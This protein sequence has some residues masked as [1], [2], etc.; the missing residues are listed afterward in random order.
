MFRGILAVIVL[1]SAVILMEWIYAIDRQY[2]RVVSEAPVTCRISGISS[3]LYSDKLYLEKIYAQC[4]NS[5][6]RLRVEQ[7]LPEEQVSMYLGM[8]LE[9]IEER[10]VGERL[11][12]FGK[13]F[14][15]P[16]LTRTFIKNAK[17]CQAL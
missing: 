17:P 3:R 4:P 6:L 7:F 8:A 14:D 13:S 10:R 12:G 1:I 9:C 11:F 5:E 2:M 16:P 15:L